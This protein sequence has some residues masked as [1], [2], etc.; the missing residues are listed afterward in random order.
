M[1]TILIALALLATPSVN[2][3]SLEAYTMQNARASWNYEKYDFSTVHE[4]DPDWRLQVADKDTT[5]KREYH[6][7]DGDGIALEWTTPA[8][9]IERRK[10]EEDREGG[11]PW[12]LIAFLFLIL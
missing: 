7:Q 11:I 2:W 6:F 1:N 3:D 9:P 10:N 8:A 5:E 12:L 4:H